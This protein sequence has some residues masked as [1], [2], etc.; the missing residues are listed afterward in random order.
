[1]TITEQLPGGGIVSRVGTNFVGIIM[2]DG[3]SCNI[4][5]LVVTAAVCALVFVSGIK[6]SKGFAKALQ[7]LS[8]GVQV[9][10][11]VISIFAK[12]KNYDFSDK[13][14]III[15]LLTIVYVLSLL[16]FSFVMTAPVTIKVKALFAI[17]SA[18]VT[19]IPLFVVTPIGARCLF[20]EYI[21]MIYFAVLLLDAVSDEILKKIN[22]LSIIVFAAAVVGYAVLFNAYYHINSADGQRI[23]AAIN[24][25][26]NS[27]E[28]QVSNL[29]YEAY[30]WRGN[31]EDE[32][33]A[34]RFKMFY[35]ID[36]NIKVTSIPYDKTEN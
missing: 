11:I 4:V 14:K 17:I 35:G 15:A 18:G 23:E 33:W 13:I 30:V 16:V 36:E 6:T 20:A 9:L 1:M 21:L 8:L 2:R 34:E 7:L 29:P 24:D 31:V 12:I 27:D 28:I 22:R 25:S 10:Y 19:I 3:F 5:L 26:Q 32:I